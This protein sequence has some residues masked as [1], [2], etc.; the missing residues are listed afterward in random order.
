MKNK[1]FSLSFIMLLIVFSAFSLTVYAAS[2]TYYSTLAFQGEHSG[3]HEHTHIKIFHTQ[4]PHIVLL[5]EKP[6]PLILAILKL[7]RFLSIEKLDGSHLKRLEVKILVD[8]NTV[9][10]HGQMLVLEIITSILKKREMESM[11]ILTMLL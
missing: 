9:Q 3:Q 1:I 8:I 6:L 4:L 7:I 2:D 11:L 10:L 5:A